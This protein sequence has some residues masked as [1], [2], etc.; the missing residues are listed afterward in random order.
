MKKE[1]RTHFELRAA[2]RETGIS[3]AQLMRAC[4]VK[5]T[6]VWRWYHGK[7]EIPGYVWSILG[8]I[9]KQKPSQILKGMPKIWVV[10]FED[11]FSEGET[12]RD[13][14]KRFHPDKTGR[15][16]NLELAAISEFKN[17]F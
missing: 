5:P 4:S 8:L 7:M 2:L 14:I 17:F 11:V 10:E 12:Y 16:T 6:T 3:Q 13:L 1:R 15:E 9:D